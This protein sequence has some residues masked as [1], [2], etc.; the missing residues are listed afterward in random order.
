[1]SK[2]A[3]THIMDETAA[4]LMRRE[5]VA[6]QQTTTTEAAVTYLRKILVNMKNIHYVYAIDKFSKLV[7]VVSIRELISSDGSLLVEDVM[8]KKVITLT[9]NKDQEIVAK[10]FQDSDL[11][12]IPVIDSKGRIAGVVQVEDILDVMQLE[13]TEDLHKMASI[14]TSGEK[15]E[16]SLMDATIG[17]LYRKRIGWLIILVFMN[18]FSGAGIAHFEDVISANIALVFFLPLL[19]DSGG[20]AGSQSATLVIRA[21]AIGDVT[22]KD[23]FKMFTKELTVSFAMGFTMA[24]AVSLVGFIRGGLDIAI[25]VA[26]T[27]TVIVV[28]GSIIGMS[29]PFV[30]RKF[31]LDPAT[32]SAPIITS[33]CDIVGVLTYF[34]IASW[35]LSL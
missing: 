4:S 12:T 11:V 1:M 29:L 30:F 3:S 9:K 6:V 33:V 15:L 27:M 25:V 24:F 20:N 7:G 26:T 21:M 35:F 22:I 2:V 8:I 13:T 31:D 16:G 19:V 34:G 18:V 5:Y 10:V 14:S 32:A 17:F 28:I 23:W